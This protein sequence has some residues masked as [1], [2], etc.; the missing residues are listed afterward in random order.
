MG[1]AALGAGEPREE[2][3]QQQ[4]FSAAVTTKTHVETV[5]CEYEAILA[6]PADNP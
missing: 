5:A 3:V 2:V 1:H 4:V 6:S